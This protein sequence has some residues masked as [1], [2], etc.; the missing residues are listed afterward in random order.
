MTVDE[1]AE[2]LV[3][4]GYVVEIVD[5]THVTATQEN[6]KT[7]MYEYRP[8]MLGGYWRREQAKR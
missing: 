3:E 1:L 6:S 2:W 7:V 4:R 8:T 5:A